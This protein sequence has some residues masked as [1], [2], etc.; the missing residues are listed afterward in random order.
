MRW[1]RMSFFALAN[2]NEIAGLA[3]SLMERLFKGKCALKEEMQREGDVNVVEYSD[4]KSEID[5]K[6]ESISMAKPKSRQAE[7]IFSSFKKEMS[8]YEAT[9]TLTPNLKILLDAL[10]TIRPTSTQNKRNLPAY[11]I[12]VMK[13]RSRPSDRAINALCVLKFHFKNNNF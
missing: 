9:C 8:L 4:M 3:K 1:K 10:L 2:K 13:Q 11:G 7:T 6:Y 12:F 5:L